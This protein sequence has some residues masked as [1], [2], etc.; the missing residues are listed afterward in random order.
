MAK[1]KVIFYATFREIAGRSELRL[2]A[3]DLQGLLRVLSTRL[4]P[5][6]KDAV[7][8]PEGRVIL[9]NGKNRGEEKMVLQDDDEVAIFPPV[10]GG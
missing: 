7:R 1:I 6:F 10:S 5:R 2:E 9:V 3:D 4:G 8:S